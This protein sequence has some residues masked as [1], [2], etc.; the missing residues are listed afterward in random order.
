MLQKI[1]TLIMSLSLLFA[2]AAPVSLPVAVS[3]VSPDVQKSVCEG[4]KKLQISPDNPTG[5]PCAE[6]TDGGGTTKVNLLLQKIIN[7]FS[8]IVGVV[9]VVMIIWGGFKYITSGGTSEKVTT[10]KNTILYAL[11]GLIIV[12]LAQIIVR[13]VLA[14]ST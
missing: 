7:I 11:I 9:A 5:E 12:A 10:A 4:A 1:K 14:K 8:V 6:D 2:F 13:F 3:A